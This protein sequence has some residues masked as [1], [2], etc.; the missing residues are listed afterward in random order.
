MCK[1]AMDVV[2]LQAM[3]LEIARQSFIRVRDIHAVELV[4]RVESG[5]KAGTSQNLL[6][7]EIMAWQGRYQEAAQLYVQERQLEKVWWK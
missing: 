1:T 5:L 3:Q 7:G 2:V 4:N 6:L